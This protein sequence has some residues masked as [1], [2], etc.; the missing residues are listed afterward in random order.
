MRAPGAL[1]TCA[2]VGGSTLI[3]GGVAHLLGKTL[4][5]TTEEC[6]ASTCGGCSSSLYMHRLW[7]LSRSTIVTLGCVISWPQACTRVSAG[8]RSWCRHNHAW[9]L[10]T[11]HTCALSRTSLKVPVLCMPRMLWK[12]RMLP[13]DAQLLRMELCSAG[14]GNSA[15]SG[16]YLQLGPQPYRHDDIPAHVQHMPIRLM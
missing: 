14:T 5:M 9:W 15:G 7:R 10:C 8:E 6:V 1:G 2:A 4:H 13:R 3:V 16:A 11:L 12:L